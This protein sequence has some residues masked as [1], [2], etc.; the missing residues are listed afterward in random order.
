MKTD[1]DKIKAKIKKLFALSQSPNANGAA[2]A[3]ETAQKLMGEYGI[4]KSEIPA[5]DVGENK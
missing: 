1:I 3:L 2:A 4:I 5:L